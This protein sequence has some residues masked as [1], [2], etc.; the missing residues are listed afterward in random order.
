MSPVY[1]VKIKLLL[2][3]WCFSCSVF[4]QCL[5]IILFSLPILPPVITV[6]Y[7]KWL[8]SS[9]TGRSYITCI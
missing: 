5:Q 9:E 8:F 6:L 4:L 3:P 1:F 2:P 7:L